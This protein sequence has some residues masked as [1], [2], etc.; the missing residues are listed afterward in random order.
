MPGSDY[1]TDLNMN[2]VLYKIKEQECGVCEV[3]D[4]NRG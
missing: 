3:R 2:V 4:E 1:T